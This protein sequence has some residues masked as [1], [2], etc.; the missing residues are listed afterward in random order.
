MRKG[1]PVVDLC[2]YVG[3][4][5]PVKLLTY[6]LPEIPEGYDWDV[7]TSEALTTRM[8]THGSKIALPDGMCYKMLVVQRN[9]DMPLHVLRH[10]AQLIEQGGVVY[11]PRPDSSASLKDKVDSVEYKKIVD[12][13][14]GKED[15]VS[16]KRSV[17]K[18]TLYWGMSLAEA[19]RQAGIRPDMGIVS[20]NTPTDK[21]YFAHR[22][23]ADADVYF[24][25]NHS[26]RSL[27]MRWFCVPLYRMLLIGIL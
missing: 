16:G 5:P 25:D 9:N 15:V 2:I 3:Q 27:K 21:V 17:G 24:V 26:Q 11:A 13:L 6:R 10:I 20:G 1:M 23:L 12:Q 14:W 22:R 7:C 18:G 8:S 19:L 4:N